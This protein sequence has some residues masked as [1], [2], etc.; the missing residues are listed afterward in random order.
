MVGLGSSG[1]K[2]CPPPL[3]AFISKLLPTS[4]NSVAA[5]S[6]TLYVDFPGLSTWIGNV[7]FFLDNFIIELLLKLP[8]I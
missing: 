7:L 1:C 4:C 6:V 2:N 5:I 8:P 3:T